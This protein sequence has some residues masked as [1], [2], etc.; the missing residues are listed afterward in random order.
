MSD[1]LYTEVHDKPMSGDQTRNMS[2]GMLIG[3]FRTSPLSQRLLRPV[4]SDNTLPWLF[5]EL[6]P[7]VNYEIACYSMVYFHKGEQVSLEM[8]VFEDEIERI[9]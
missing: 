2:S 1:S 8:T 5:R 4:S 7:L 3:R 9:C 6:K